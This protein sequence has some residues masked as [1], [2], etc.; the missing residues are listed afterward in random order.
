MA[1]SNRYDWK[2]GPPILENHSRCK[3]DII[4]E[5]LIQYMCVVTKGSL[6]YRNKE[7]N[8]TIVDGFAGGGKYLYENREVDGS[9]LILL[10]AVKEATMLINSE[11]QGLGQDAL[12]I[13]V[14][15]FFVEKDK[16][17]AKYLDNTLIKEGYKNGKV[18]VM[19]G[20]FGSCL[21][22]IIECIKT[23]SR[24]KR[25]RALF[26]LDQYGYSKVLLG[27][28]MNIMQSAKSEIILTFAVGSLLAYLCDKS[29]STLMKIGLTDTDIAQIRHKDN[30]DNPNKCRS[31]IQHVLSKQFLEMGYFYTP[32][33]IYGDTSGWGYWLVHLSSHYRA[34]D[35][36]MKI[37]WNKGNEMVHY[38]KEG[39]DMFGYRSKQDEKHTRQL[40]IGFAFRF[41][42][43]AKEKVRTALHSEIPEL[44]HQK[45]SMAY[46][47][48]LNEIFN[49]TPANREIINQVL[50]K[51]VE[52]KEFNIPRREVK[53]IKD[54]DV[55]TV[56]RQKSIFPMRRK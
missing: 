27:Q 39:L 8:L 44:I 17:T 33:C 46:R 3:H 49:H 6:R 5:Y 20:Q 4:R 31:V 34:R 22:Q 45:G 42:Q 51:G 52:N 2:N 54:D 40:S 56:S 50:W 37:H 15:F 48:L 9:P 13:N 16:A 7:F 38:G 53:N 24:G 12:T 32:F 28:V 1:S 18:Q 41:D 10:Q 55:I 23:K 47:D 11:R 29:E 25:G 43:L 26:I 21:P 36:M 35:E 30:R 19:H 14:D